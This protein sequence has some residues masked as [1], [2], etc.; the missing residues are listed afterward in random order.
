MAKPEPYFEIVEGSDGYFRISLADKYA[1]KFVYVIGGFISPA[2]K[3]Y[4][5]AERIG[6]AYI[7]ESSRLKQ[8]RRHHSNL[9]AE[10]AAIDAAQSSL[11]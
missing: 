3:D 2:F 9:V 10:Q 6:W 11:F 4:T 5:E 7:S 1:R 8:M